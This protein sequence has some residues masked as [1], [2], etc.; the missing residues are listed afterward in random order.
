M[1][2]KLAR[3]VTPMMAKAKGHWRAITLVDNC[4][5]PSV[6]TCLRLGMVY[7]LDSQ[8]GH[9]EGCSKADGV[10]VEGQKEEA[11]VHQEAPDGNVREHTAEE[12]VAVD[13]N[14]AVPVDGEE[15]PGQWQSSHRNVDEARRTGVVAVVNRSE[16]EE[17]EDHHDF[18]DDIHVMRPEH[19]PHPVE[20]VETTASY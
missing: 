14:G 8:A 11:G 19:D 9:E 18:C 4:L 7:L 5:H 2:A 15:G 10:V 20:H 1:C 17:V 12:A 6:S 16:L 3:K 13:H